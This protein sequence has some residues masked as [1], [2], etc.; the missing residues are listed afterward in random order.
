MD[1]TPLSSGPTSGGSGPDA[2]AALADNRLHPS[3]NRRIKRRLMYAWVGLYVVS[4][5][6]ACVLILRGPSAPTK[7]SQSHAQSLLSLAQGGGD[8]IGWISIHGPIYNSQSGRPWERGAEQWVRRIQDMS[9]TKGVKA[10]ILDI[11]SPGGSVGAVQEIHSQIMR[12]R[13]AKKIPFVAVFGDV[14]ASGGYYIASAC[15]KVISHPGTLTG[16]IGVIFSF[17]NLESLFGKVGVKM[18]TI[19]SGKFKDIGS[20]SRGMTPEERTLLQ[21]VIDD[22]YG[23]FLAAVAEGRHMPADKV[24]PLADGRIYTGNQALQVNLVDQLGDS[25]DAVAL[26]AKLGGITGK[27]RVRREAERF[28]DLFELLDS[29]FHGLLEGQSSL[30]D[31]LR[32]ADRVGLAYLWSGW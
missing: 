32:S 30:F 14:A 25:E 5:A 19:K 10:I 31:S 15:D 2:P 12:I 1:T 3:G 9:E 18:E 17:S 4:L 28:S 16:S 20:F 26:A 29:R 13:K 22:A 24:K 27:P 6:A 21:A 8:S 7:G 23:Q 11:N